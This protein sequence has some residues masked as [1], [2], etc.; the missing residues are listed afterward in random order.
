MSLRA[1]V[2]CL[3][4]ACA[5]PVF[6]AGPACPDRPLRVGLYEAG[7]LY[8]AGSGVD[9]DML[10]ELARRTGCRFET[11]PLP[12]ARAYMWLRG[13]Q[14]D[15]LMSSVATPER[16]E[17]AW[18]LPY[19]Q[20]KFVTI[21]RADVA[22][23]KTTRDAFLADPSLRLGVVRGLYHGA[24]YEEWDALLLQAGR[25]HYGPNLQ[26]LFRMLKQ[27]RFHA[28]Y[29]VPLQYRKELQDHA[30]HGSIRIVDWF[31]AAPPVVGNMGLSKRHFSA[32]EA[33][34][35]RAQVQA[36]KADGTLRRILLKYIPPDEARST[37]AP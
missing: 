23:E 25:L 8:S 27:D 21:L 5:A 6:A 10:D 34:K 26:T 35:W 18:F 33:A 30:M 12:R 29:A 11:T 9:R 36:L 14:I 3:P 28:L 15:L 1:F 4:L 37:V 32:E 17:H 13:G 22:P 31:P 7:F 2:C 24:A 20:Q 19:I 16:S